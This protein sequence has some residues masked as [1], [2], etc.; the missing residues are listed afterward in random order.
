MDLFEKEQNVYDNANE[1]LADIENGA[2]L[3]TEEF[4]AL[5]KEYGMLLK[6]MRR[7][8]KFADRATGHLHKKN[9]DLEGKVYY[10]PLTGIH[11]RRFLEENIKRTIKDLSRSGSILSIMMLDI[12]FFK[13][14][15][16]TYGHSAGDDCLK[17]VAQAFLEYIAREGDFVARYGGEEFF[18][19]LPNA[20]EKGAQRTAQKILKK[21]MA[22]R[23]P[24]EKNEAADCVT[25]SI[26]GTT[27]NVKHTD[28]ITDY[29]KRADEALYMSKHN[30]RN[31]YT[32]LQYNEN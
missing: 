20:S 5:V 30:G 11:N 14:Y 25:V 15:N 17:A 27:I 19:A 16:D 2:P 12:D 18:I 4:S 26:G 28:N 6:H 29:V 8:T 7:I 10:D 23:I 21:I 13:K 9:V 1:H 31:K 32:Y 22:L 3:K 24:H